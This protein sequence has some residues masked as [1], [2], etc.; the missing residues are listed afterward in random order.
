[1]LRDSK[2]SFNEK[3]TEKLK[4]ESLTTKDWW[5]TVKHFISPNIKTTIPPLEVD[6][7][8]YTDERDKANILNNFFRSQTILDATNA[9]LPD[10]EPHADRSQLSSIVLSPVEVESILKTLT[11]GKVFG[12]NALNNRVL[13][14]ISSEL[15]SPFC[16]FFTQ[17]LHTGIMPISYK[18]AN[19]CPVPKTG[20]L[21]TVSN[22]RPI[23]LLNSE[24]KLFEK[25]IFKYLFNHFRDN[26][27]LSS[28]QSGFI[29]GDSTV[30]KLTYLYNTFCEALDGGKEV[31]AIFCDI[32]KA[33]DRVWHAG[34]LYKLEAAGVTEVLAWFKNYLSDRKQRV[35][36]PGVTSDW[37]S[38]RAGVPQ[39][40][41]LGPLPFLLY[42]NYIVADIA[43]NIRLF[44]DDTGL[45]II[46]ENPVLSADCLNRDLDKIKQWA[47]TWLVSFNPSKTETL[48]I[49]RKVNRPQ[50]PTLFM[51]DVQI[52]EV[53]YHKHLGLNFSNDGSWNQ[54]IRHITEKA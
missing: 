13:R 41:I 54:H 35:V 33:F 22:Y 51:Q 7:Y 26:N 38:I 5:S 6:N 43:F 23:S 24:A 47:T 34:L 1:M 17:S 44:A 50:Q 39:G 21:S 19:V 3:L 4:S 2:M 53:D 30:N 8:I 42:I 40:S 37:A 18:E 12:P 28:L 11:V 10:Q 52:K 9:T 46:V 14:E 29:P 32:S 25:L 45:F 48:L 16:S 27:L 31:R 15:S 20:D 36:L 49:S